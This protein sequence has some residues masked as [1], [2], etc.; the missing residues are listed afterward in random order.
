MCHTII[1]IMKRYSAEWTSSSPFWVGGCLKLRTP[2]ISADLWKPHLS[3]FLKILCSRHHHR[4]SWKFSTVQSIGP[5]REGSSLIVRYPTRSLV[6][7][8]SEKAA[9]FNPLE[10]SCGLDS[11]AT[12][13]QCWESVSSFVPYSV[14]WTVLWLTKA[15]SEVWGSEQRVHD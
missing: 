9:L 8:P 2:P 1:L 13:I 12:S 14:S 11:L 5:S 6:D 15:W 10:G 7:R 4:I 3:W